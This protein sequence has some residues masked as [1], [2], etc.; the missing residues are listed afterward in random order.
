[1]DAERAAFEAWAAEYG[2]DLGRWTLGMQYRKVETM[3]AWE[4]WQEA[5]RTTHEPLNHDATWPYDLSRP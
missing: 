1:M 5:R 3:V 2:L 4:A